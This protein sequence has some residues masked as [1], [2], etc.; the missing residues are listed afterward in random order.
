MAH[1]ISTCLLLKSHDR[2]PSPLNH[3]SH[4]PWLLDPYLSNHCTA[5]YLNQPQPPPP[6][7]GPAGTCNQAP[8]ARPACSLQG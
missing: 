2:F 4:P 3:P 8:K 7:L 6:I 1:Q 5:S